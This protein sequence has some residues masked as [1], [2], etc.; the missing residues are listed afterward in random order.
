MATSRKALLKEITQ[1][2][3]RFANAYK[4]VSKEAKKAYKG[5]TK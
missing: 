2:K 4:G 5:A 1:W 3:K